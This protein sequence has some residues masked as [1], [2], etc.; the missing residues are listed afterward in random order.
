MALTQDPA[1]KPTNP[2]FS[3]KTTDAETCEGE[4]WGRASQ[5]VAPTQEGTWWDS[6]VADRARE[7][8]ASHQQGSRWGQ[9]VRQLL[10]A[11]HVV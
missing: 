11:V 10:K 3:Q 1:Q 6:E 2:L 5:L 7:P 4:G 8:E 9:R